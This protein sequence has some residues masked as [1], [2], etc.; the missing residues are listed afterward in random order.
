[1]RSPCSPP[2]T[3]SKMGNPQAP[4]L[5]TSLDDGSDGRSRTDER[6]AAEASHH[7]LRGPMNPPAMSNA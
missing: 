4:V 6:P 5:G 2:S 7:P 3:N 1:M